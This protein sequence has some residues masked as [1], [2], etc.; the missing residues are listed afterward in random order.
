MERIVTFSA[1]NQHRFIPLDEVLPVKYNTRDFDKSLFSEL[2]PYWQTKVQYAQKV[3]QSDP[4]RIQIKVSQNVFPVNL[5][6]YK[7]GGEQVS[8]PFALTY[9]SSL[10]PIIEDGIQRYVYIYEGINFWSL[11][12]GLYYLV[13]ECKFDEDGDTVADYTDLFVSEP[14]MV[15]EKHP[16]TTLIEYSNSTNKDDI[17]F[18]QTKQKFSFR[19]EGAVIK[20]QPKVDRV[21]FV[22]QGEDS[23]QLSA[24]P[25]RSWEFAA[26]FTNGGVPFWVVEK[27]NHIFTLDGIYIEGK[28]YTTIEG[29]QFKYEQEDPIYPLFQANIE[30]GDK[31]NGSL[32]TFN[33]GGMT[34]LSPIPAYP[35]EIYQTEIGY[36]N[37]V[38]FIYSF[39]RRIDDLTELNA[40]IAARNSAITANGMLGN[41]A[42]SNNTLVYNRGANESY[43]YAYCGVLTKRIGIKHTVSAASTIEFELF[44]AGVNAS[45]RYSTYSP[46]GALGKFGTVPNSI[47]SIDPFNYNAASAGT[48]TYD[49]FHDG[50]LNVINMLGVDISGID[51]FG[52][53]DNIPSSLAEF[54]I[55]LSNKLTSF[56][57]WQELG[58]AARLTLE[59]VVF[60]GNHNL[61]NLGDGYFNPGV[62]LRFKKLRFIHLADNNLSSADID[63]FYNSMLDA[64]YAIAP[65]AFPV[66]GIISTAGQTPTALPT[67]ASAS[68]RDILANTLNWTIT[69]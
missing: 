38:E 30:I 10:P 29:S 13:I 57:I 45:N 34:L 39:P 60:S 51:S 20:P 11:L 47:T 65:Y 28:G 1:A 12:E 55:I 53:T 31:D 42:I 17:I 41:I 46:T 21:V 24:T 61:N 40:W 59:R 25:F 2:E 22:D 18:E 6:V 4:L 37:N 8:G 26:G 33:R 16:K 56:D 32:H 35:F 69:S 48:Y 54:A 19:V 9:L 67:G 27:L 44:L 66:D 58:I 5:Y 43:N 7:C 64:Y 15:K 23:V 14:V 62:L 68:A 50:S 52:D 3:Q 49:L 63:A 36:V